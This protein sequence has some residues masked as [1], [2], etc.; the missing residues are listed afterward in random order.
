[1][2]A[3]WSGRRA[4]KWLTRTGAPAPGLAVEADG[5][6]DFALTD[7]DGPPRSKLTVAVDGTPS[8]T[9]F[10]K[11]GKPSATLQPTAKRKP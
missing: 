4:S 10:D 2:T 1:M 9:F 3:K 8:L 6:A 7:R 5:T 11:H